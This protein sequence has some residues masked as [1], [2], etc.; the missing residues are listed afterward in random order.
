MRTVL[1]IVT[2]ILLTLLALTATAQ[3]SFE[4]GDNLVGNGSFESLSFSPDVNLSPWQ[5]SG[6]MSLVV[7][8]PQRA[9][10]GS[11]FA[12]VCGLIYQ[13][14]ATVPGL[15]YEVRFAFGGNEQEQQNRESLHVTWASQEIAT[16]PV[17]PV[18][19]QS[20]QWRYLTYD[21]VTENNTT[22]LGFTSYP[23]QAFPYIDEVSVVVVPE[24]SVFSLFAFVTVGRFGLSLFR[25]IV[26]TRDRGALESDQEPG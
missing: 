26:T 10:E 6:C 14:I 23:G 1:R 18:P 4:R 24:P 22:R 8:E 20:P 3:S 7:N 12:V 9:A 13:D 15:T 11:N 19:Q 21:V 25:L 2:G 17:T 5:W 16:I